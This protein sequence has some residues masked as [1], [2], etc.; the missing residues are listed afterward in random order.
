M[1]TATSERVTKNTTKRLSLWALLVGAILMIPLLANFP[2]TGG[3][4]I[5]AG[6]VLFGAALGFELATKNIKDSKD[7]L[8]VAAATVGMIIVIWGLA[9]AD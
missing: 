4:Y 1:K 2:W 5:F 6:T 3:D 8:F 7:R 9:V